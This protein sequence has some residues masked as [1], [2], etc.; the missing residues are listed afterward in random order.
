[1]VA[2]VNDTMASLQ[3][4]MKSWGGYLQEIDG[5]SI[6]L[7]VPAARFDDALQEVARM[8]E[9]IERRVKAQDVTEEM[10]DLKI[11]LDNA[12]RTRVRLLDLLEKTGRIEDAVKVEQELERVTETIELLKGKIQFL[13]AQ[14]AYSTIRVDLN[15]PVPQQTLAMQIP[16]PWVLRLADGAVTGTAEGSA[17]RGNWFQRGVTFD[18]PKGF[19][20]YFERS[21]M[22]EAMSGAGVVLKVT[23]QENYDGGDLAFWSPLVRRVL[24]E[25]RAIALSDTR[26]VTLDNGSAG[27]LYAG[28]K[29]AGNRRARYL[30]GLVAGKHY[31]WAFEAWGEEKAFADSA[32]EIEKAFKSMDA[33]R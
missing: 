15:S 7:R 24:T 11:R 29:D 25:S 4:K 6:T 33:G 27:E 5:A 2:N 20:R 26:T 14:A 22:T 17:Q 9:V 18:L 8:G 19:I 32:A 21:S 31:V 23:R 16:F 10:R 1:V 13:S 3:G 12:E 30:L 28:V